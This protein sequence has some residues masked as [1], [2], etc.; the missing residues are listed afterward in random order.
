MK[1][2]KRASLEIGVNT[3]VILVIAM[4]LMALAIGFVRGI[5]TRA[6]AVPDVIDPA[7]L[8]QPPDRGTPV[9]MRPNVL[10]IEP[11]DSGTTVL[12]VY[13]WR[14]TNAYYVSI[15][16]MTCSPPA[17]Q[18][19]M[20]VPSHTAIDLVSTASGQQIARDLRVGGVVA[21]Q[22]IIE[23][24]DP[25]DTAPTTDGVADTYICQ[26]EVSTQTST[27]TT[28]KETETIQFTVKTS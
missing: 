10:N 1:L 23:V 19:V 25:A 22:V 20:L 3:I 17:Q 21:S 27:S 12:S 26:F 15:D 5:F 4:I 11:G 8:Q 16:G 13:N 14:P 9:R 24:P 7:S 18:N 28:T 6:S 2:N